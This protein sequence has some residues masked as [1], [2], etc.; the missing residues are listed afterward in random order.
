M[1]YSEDFNIRISKKNEKGYH[2]KS[3]IFTVLMEGNAKIVGNFRENSLTNSVKPLSYFSAIFGTQIVSYDNKQVRQ[4]KIISKIYSLFVIMFMYLIYTFVKPKSWNDTKTDVPLNILTKCFGYLSN[5]EVTYLIFIATIGN[6]E[7]YLKLLQKLDDFDNHFKSSRKL[8]IKGRIVA[9]SL[10]LFSILEVSFTFWLRKFNIYNIGAHLTLY[11][12]MLQGTII[13][14][15]LGNI[16][17]RLMVFN[18]LLLGRVL[19]ILPSC[20]TVIFE[21][22]MGDKLIKVSIF[23]IHT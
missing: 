8:F 17:S 6:G 5:T 1:L 18:D 13:V 22:S 12:L 3:E 2:V 9:T 21:D 16:Y 14:F 11:S 10:I 4:V 7:Y 19:K 15:F 23:N 20:K